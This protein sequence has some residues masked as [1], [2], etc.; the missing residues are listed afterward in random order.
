MTGEACEAYFK[1]TS[2]GIKVPGDE[3]TLVLVDL[4]PAPNSVNDLLGRMIEGGNTRCVRALGADEEWSDAQLKTII[5]ANLRTPE[6][7][8]IVRGR[9]TDDTVSVICSESPSMGTPKLTVEQ[10]PRFYI[11]FRFGNIF[12]ALTFKHFLEND[13]DWEQCDIHYAKDPCDAPPGV[14]E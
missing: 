8:K 10:P 1:S 3:N 9:T 13:P 12:N 5:R 11:E 4:H 7:D 6:L 2:N 14:H